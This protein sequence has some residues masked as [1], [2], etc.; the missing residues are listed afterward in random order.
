MKNRFFKLICG[1]SATAGIIYCINQYFNHY[2]VRLQ[3]LSYSAENFF[4]WHN[5]KIYYEKNGSGSPILLLHD[6]NPAASSAEWSLLIDKLAESHTVYTLDLPGCGRSD[7]PDMLYTNFVYVSMLKTFVKS[8]ISGKPAV[9]A[10]GLSTSIAL[11]AAVYDSSLF[12]NL[13]FI[14][15]VSTR[16]MKENPNFKSKVRRLLYKLPL[17]GNLIFNSV[18]AREKIDFAFTDR[19]FYNPFNVTDDLVDTYYE[20]SHLDNANGRFL[21]GCID[22]NYLH[23]YMDHAIETLTTK[24][25]IIE[26]SSIP[27]EESSVSA[28]TAINQNISAEYVPKTKY[29]PQLEKPDI[30][31]DIILN[32][33]LSF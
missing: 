1:T 12:S 20:S 3:K 16:K 22:G 18:Y 6:L 29:V 26:G 23:M 19:Y 25:I 17:V 11:M 33:T 5:I 21:A 30:V 15:P 14:N 28:W 7:K 9:V 24:A 32:S 2:A 31:A 13:I 8:L 4:N 27:K 10:T